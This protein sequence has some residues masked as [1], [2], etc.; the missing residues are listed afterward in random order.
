MLFRSILYL[1]ADHRKGFIKNVFQLCFGAGLFTLLIFIPVF[2]EYGLSFFTYYEHFP[3]PSFAKNFYKGSIGAFG[4]TGYVAVFFLMIYSIKKLIHNPSLFKSPLFVLSIVG[5]SIFKV[6]FISLPLKSAFIIPILPYLFL[7]TAF[8]ANEKYQRWTAIS[9]VVSCFFFGINLSDP[10]RGSK[11]S[12]ASFTFEVSKQKVA[13]DVFSGIFTADITKRI[14][15]THFAEK[16]L[17]QVQGIHQPTYII[18]G[19]YLSDLLVLQRNK[20]NK[21]VEF[22]YYTAEAKLDS[23]AKKNID[24]RYLPQQDELNDL[25]FNSTFTNKWAKPF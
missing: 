3:I 9:L 11:E 19:W 6:A 18:A 21:L 12:A 20:E 10:L 1:I 5:I 14:N 8:I 24:L 2:K 4:I 15:R 7:F 16:V 17:Q 22:G 25:R 23:L 13:F